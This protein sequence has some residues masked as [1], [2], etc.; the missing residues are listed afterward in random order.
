MPSES[1]NRSD[2]AGVIS[3]DSVRDDVRRSAALFNA[4][5]REARL[6]AWVFGLSPQTHFWSDACYRILGV[7][8]PS[9]EPFDFIAE[10][11]VEEHRP[12]MRE[13]LRRAI[14]ERL[15]WSCEVEIARRND[16]R[17]VW[18]FV[19]GEP[20]LD[21]SGALVCLR[22]IAQ[23]VDP[24]RRAIERLQRSEERFATLFQFMPEPMTLMK[25]ATGTIVDVNDAWCNWSGY[26]RAEAIGR[27]AAG[28]ALAPREER[29]RVQAL[30]QGRDELLNVPVNYLTRQGEARIMNLSIRRLELDGELHSISALRDQTE[31]IQTLDQLRER[32]QMLSLTIAAADLGT[33]DWDLKGGVISGDT[34]WRQHLGI[35]GIQGPIT[36]NVLSQGVHPDDRET[37]R[38]AV[39]AFKT[40]RDDHYDVVR[41]LQLADGSS[42][43]IRNIGR[44]VDRTPDG[45]PARVLGVTLDVT[46]QREHEMS[47][48]RSAHYDMLTGLPNRELLADRL[49]QAMALSRRTGGLLAVAYLDLDG[50][51]PINDR[52]GHAMG[53][54]LL[55][56]LA[57]RMRERSRS[58]DTAARVGGDEFVLLISNLESEEPGLATLDRVME[59]I[60]SP[61]VVDGLA[62]QVT[63]SI[64]VTFFPSD[65]SDAIT[66]LRHA[67]QAMYRAKQSGRNQVRSFDAG[68]EQQRQERS[69]TLVRLRQ[70]LN[71]REFE[72]FVQ[73][74]VDMVSAVV[75]GAEALVRWRHPQDGVLAPARFLSS[76]EG[77]EMD[78]PFGEWV[79]DAAFEILAAWADAGSRRQLAVNLTALHL[80]SPGLIEGIGRRL[81]AHPEVGACQIEIEVT[82]SAALSD[83]EAAGA[84]VEALRALGVSTALD[85]FGTG[86]A[87]LAYLRRLPV[88]T[89]KIDKSFVQGM[90]G[91]T[92][93][94]AIVE[95]VIAMARSFGKD[96]VAEG[97]ETVE[98]GTRLVALGGRLAQGYCIARPMPVSDFLPWC[99]RWA[100]PPEWLQQ[101]AAAGSVRI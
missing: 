88:N 98:H 24:S 66:L 70:A 41:H 82:E 15:P 35:N 1:A 83:V 63:A 40:S 9:A 80:Q 4:V 13:H 19:F 61:F 33:W 37:A 30:F 47:L 101:G 86:Y 92:G 34:R 45:R 12:V 74:K 97:V 20:V 22:G 43:W 62:L 14:Q 3:S 32:E 84:I 50:F 96:V 73:P 93:D 68:R 94:R 29:E 56:E 54:R 2:G 57:R 85:D 60:A 79:L 26:S 55:V 28:L 11:V 71:Q 10:S 49:E 90:V 100:I 6:G 46:Q 27:T 76:I 16:G 69:Q 21:P 64:G 95:A 53:D 7:D 31:L 39:A 36:G 91:N 99:E 44:I 75:V 18:L 8:D 58:V 5:G 72:L 51:K 42:R 77:S 81:A 59:A 89:L 25:V 67:D 78:V 52:H 87:S 23:D 48:Q 38:A 65:P 17:R